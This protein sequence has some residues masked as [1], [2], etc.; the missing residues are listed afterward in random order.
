MFKRKTLKHTFRL[1]SAFSTGKRLGL[2][3]GSPA[4]LVVFAESVDPGWTV[5]VDGLA[6]HTRVANGYQLA[7][8]VPA[9]AREVVFAY[10]PARG[11]TGL[12]LSAGSALMLMAWAGW[13]RRRRQAGGAERA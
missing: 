2:P 4:G 11:G 13:S 5:A 1:V 9:G 3:P 12:A 6:A 7:V 8:E 10:R